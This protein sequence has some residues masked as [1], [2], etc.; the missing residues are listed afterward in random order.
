MQIQDIKISANNLWP[1][2]RRFGT[3]SFPLSTQLNG[4]NEIV[5][6]ELSP[7]RLLWPHDLGEIV[8]SELLPA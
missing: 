4:R 5:S 2:Q 6:S 8:S 3:E 1:G 7:A